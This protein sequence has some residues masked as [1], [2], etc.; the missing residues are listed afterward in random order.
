MRGYGQV[1][2]TF[3]INPEIQSLSDQGKLLAVYLLSGQHSTAIGC[4]RLPLGYVQ[5][6]MGWEKETVSKRFNELLK[7]GFINRDET[8]GWTLVLNFLKFNPIANPNVAKKVAREFT[9]IPNSSSVYN[10]LVT[11]LQL[12]G[13]HFED[14]FL[15]ALESVHQ[16]VSKPKPDPEPKPNPDPNPKHKPE[17]NLVPIPTISQSEMHKNSN[18]IENVFNYWKT[19]MN[20]P[21]AVLDKKRR[22]KIK[23]RLTD[24]YTPIDLNHAIDGCAK[25]P[26]NMGDNND[27]TVYDSLE[28]ILR[29]AEHVDRFLKNNIN[30]P[31]PKNNAQRRVDSNVLEAQEFI[32]TVIGETHAR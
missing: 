9:T 19:R 7:I 18:V 28:L 6:D 4:M 16:T 31:K 25:T 20:H 27:G 2:A 22:E 26:F 11:V 10:S 24:G 17:T 21:K 15:N 32:N 3:W 29:D 8:T 5:E 14:E 1:Q 23:A 30:P 13:K 12:Y